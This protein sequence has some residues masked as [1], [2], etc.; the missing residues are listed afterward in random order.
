M[1]ALTSKTEESIRTDASEPFHGFQAAA[2][3]FLTP[4][5]KPRNQ[6]K[7]IWGI[8][9]LMVPHIMLEYNVEYI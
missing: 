9:V 4:S 3:Y 5:V 6:N 7:P 2:Y 1:V 8:S